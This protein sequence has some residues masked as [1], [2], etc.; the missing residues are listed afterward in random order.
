M[1]WLRAYSRL[2]WRPLVILWSC[3]VCPILTTYGLP[4]PILYQVK[5]IAKERTPFPISRLGEL[6]L[7]QSSEAASQVLLL[8]LTLLDPVTLTDPD[9]DPPNPSL[10]LYNRD[11][12]TLTS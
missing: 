11:P 6:L 2:A 12:E 8:T 5:Q 4:I 1:L 7:L 9:T 3:Y 10:A